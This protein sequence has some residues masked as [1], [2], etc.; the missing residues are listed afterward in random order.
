MVSKTKVLTKM[1]N[2]LRCFTPSEPS[3]TATM[4]STKLDIPI[5]TMHGILADLVAL[6]FLVQS[7]FSKEYRIGLRFMEMGFLHTNNFELNNIAH[8]IMHNLSSKVEAMVGL[9]VVYNGW[10]YVSMSVLPIETVRDLKY[11]GPRLPAHH[12]AGGMA[13]LAHLPQ[14]DINKYLSMDW[15]NDFPVVHYDIEDIEARLDQVRENGYSIGLNPSAKGKPRTVGAPV[16]GR[17]H[18]VLAGL[19][20]IGSSEGLSDKE[21]NRILPLLTSS[22]H[23]ISLRCGHLMRNSNH[24]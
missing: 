9:S 17:E 8:G 6:D 3:W 12:S 20:V 7:P 10:M 2:I 11:L 18:Q 15:Q 5:T 22:A 21:L 4:L 24:L 14:E 1:S 23:E 13:V 19:V 16:F